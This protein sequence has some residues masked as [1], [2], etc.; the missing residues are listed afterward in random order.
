MLKHLKFYMLMRLVKDPITTAQ[1]YHMIYHKGLP[2]TKFE[3]KFKTFEG[4][5]LSVSTEPKTKVSNRRQE[6]VTALNELKS[7]VNKTK[8]D[9]ESIGILEATLKNV[10]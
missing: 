9:K 1:I 2:P 4:E 5:K 3:P 8:Q 7:K 10:D 6:M